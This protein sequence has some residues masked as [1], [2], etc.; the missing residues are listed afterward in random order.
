VL[1][2]AF[3]NDGMNDMVERLRDHSFGFGEMAE[4]LTKQHSYDDPFDGMALELSDAEVKVA[5]K[6]PVHWKEALDDLLYTLNFHAA[7]LPG[8]DHLLLE[9]VILPF[10]LNVVA[11]MP[12]KSARAIIALHEAGKLEISA[13]KVEVVD[14]DS[15]RDTRVQVESE[16]GGGSELR[17]RMFVDCS[18]QKPL[19][20]EE[21]PFPALVR[22]KQ[23]TEALA[24]FA[25]AASA[26]SISEGNR[27]RVTQEGAVLALKIGGI[28]VSDN[29]RVMDASSSAQA[30]IHDVAFPHMTGLRP[31]SYGLQACNET[32]AKVVQS[33]LDGDQHQCTRMDERPDYTLS[34]LPGIRLAPNAKQEVQRQ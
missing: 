4:E 26:L 13:G 22:E 19:Q 3:T 10:A 9:E 1:A 5:H 27:Q 28:R 8:E 29:Y 33:W 31:Y 32:A 14:D 11:A 2:E 18:G 15:A 20:L 16:E 34:P 25:D 21:F 24:P 12:L 30:P 17:Y 23:V 6:K 7:L